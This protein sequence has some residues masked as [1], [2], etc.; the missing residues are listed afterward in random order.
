M[1]TMLSFAVHSFSSTDHAFAQ[2]RRP[3][4]AQKPPGVRKMFLAAEK[5]YRKG[6]YG[7]AMSAFA[8][9]LRYYPQHMP[10]ILLY[11]KSAYRLDRVKDAYSLFT[12]VDVNSLDPETSYEYGLAF[13]SQKKFAGSLNGFRRIPQG[14]PL[15]DLANY[16][17]GISAIKIRN[18][19]LAQ[20][21]MERAVV[22]P[23]KLVAS[24]SL[25]LKHL[26]KILLMKESDKLKKQ[27]LKEKNRLKKRKGRKSKPPKTT[28]KPLVY[29]HNGW[30]GRDNNASIKVKQV[31]Q[32]SDF[33]GF[34]D[35]RVT[36][37]T[38]TGEFKL[39]PLIEMP[40]QRSSSRRSVFV[41]QVKGKAE[42][43]NS[44]GREERILF[45]ENEGEAYRQYVED[46]R[47]KNV[48]FG[49]A[50]LAP[51]ME[52]PLPADFWISFGP[53]Y[54]IN[55]PEFESTNRNGRWSLFLDFGRKLPDIEFGA[56][57]KYSNYF[58]DEYRDVSQEALAEIKSKL[59]FSFGLDSE[60]KLVHKSFQYVEESRI[61]GPDSSTA[62]SAELAQA[63]P[64]GFK[65]K[66]FGG[67][68]FLSN[69]VVYDKGSYETIAADGTTLTGK[70]TLEY[71]PF[72]WI[73]A[74]VGQV[75]SRTEWTAIDPSDAEESWQLNVAD[76][77]DEFFWSIKLKKDF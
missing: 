36:S 20:A 47:Q 13:F 9:L 43:L 52:F 42:F 45:F 50:E 73:E 64:V 37:T 39:A 63:L 48:K 44:D 16:Y 66:G 60:F 57:T 41:V 5:L 32:D 11:A 18:Y 59:I 30:K 67:F 17:G 72:D 54:F 34:A 69:W 68:E 75:V 12:R 46:D 2:A 3:T 6:Q 23:D 77:I 40:Y 53:E 56:K 71:A 26:K 35:K 62:I 74:A 22:L 10:S 70:L 31:I 38:Q 65:I 14:H 33:H 15:Y 49:E 21:M 25:Y 58:D 76:A 55:W 28:K 1:L 4:T 7:A 19:E 24:R 51:W 61:E 8:N 27:R 29:E